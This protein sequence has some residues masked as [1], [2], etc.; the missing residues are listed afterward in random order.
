MHIFVWAEY[1]STVPNSLEA[2]VRKVSI[3]DFLLGGKLGILCFV[4]GM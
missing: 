1:G 2:M 4:V 3:T